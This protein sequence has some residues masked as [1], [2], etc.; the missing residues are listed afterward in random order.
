MGDAWDVFELWGHIEKGHG[1]L[2]RGMVCQNR[3]G[4]IEGGHSTCMRLWLGQGHTKG[5]WDA[6]GMEPAY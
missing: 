4:Q 2:R 1:A 6:C 3:S 5:M